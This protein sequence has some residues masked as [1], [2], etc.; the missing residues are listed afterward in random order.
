MADDKEKLLA[1]RN[2]IDAID[3]TMHELIMRRTKVVE[4]VR[5][6][7]KDS[8]VKIRPSREA[9]ILYRLM[10]EHRG[11]FPKRE[12]ARIWREL[13]VATLS[14]EGP[15]SVAVHHLE[16][17]PD[18]WELARDHFGTF[19]TMQRH[20]SVRAVVEA[21]RE[22]T[23]TV[24]V[25]AFP[26]HE[27]TEPWWRFLVSEAP[28]TPKVIARL[29]FIP[30]GQVHNHDADALV[31]CPVEQEETGRDRSFLAIESEEDI[32]YPAIER[33]LTEAGFSATF[34][35][36]W[37]DPNRPPGWT[38]LVE[39]FGFINVGGRPLQRLHDG[40]GTRITRIIQ[41]GGYGTPLS[42]Q[43]MAPAPD[44]DNG[45]DA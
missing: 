28:E 30:G 33:V 36:L 2:E 19:T 8:N 16:D 37:H 40:L 24:G 32:G 35:Q 18:Y 21:V 41:L 26:D 29:P 3:R 7:K 4:S 23:S 27:Q 31:I 44:F 1:L 15:F 17:C 38:Y 42:D 45:D 22:Q 39:V 9:D 11:P 20:T 34:H 43:D 10:A 5:T 12:L 6:V 25:L 13:I 14:F